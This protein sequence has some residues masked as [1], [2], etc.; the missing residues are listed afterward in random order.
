VTS[1]KKRKL[2]IQERENSYQKIRDLERNKTNATAIKNAMI[3]AN[4]DIESLIKRIK[5]LIVVVV[6]ASENDI[7]R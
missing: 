2:L 7:K 3:D 5:K 6:D 4:E 1:I